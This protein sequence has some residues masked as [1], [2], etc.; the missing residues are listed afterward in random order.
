MPARILLVSLALLTVVAVARG[1]DP[2]ARSRRF[3]QAAKELADSRLPATTRLKAVQVVVA[4]PRPKRE[5]AAA[6]CRG[7]MSNSPSVHAACA[8]ALEDVAPGIRP[9]VVTLATDE[10]LDEHAAALESLAKM[11]RAAAA[12]ECVVAQQLRQ[13]AAGS[14]LAPQ[15]ADSLF[16]ACDLPLILPLV[17]RIAAQRILVAVRTAEY[18]RRYA[19]KR[20]MLACCGAAAL[21]RIASDDPAVAERSLVPLLRHPNALVRFAA[22]SGLD[23]YGGK[24][25]NCLKA[26][27]AAKTDK[28]KLVREM[29]AKVAA[30]IKDDA[31]GRTLTAQK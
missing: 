17:D 14:A 13:S 27:T 24:A 16:T 5:I 29:A 26:V 31:A 9:H 23:L 11:G 19:R 22:V 1:D 8:E 30:D 15:E 3:E 10:N 28:N 18:V 6:L 4:E 21:A 7:L 12:A 25:S 20:A 2:P